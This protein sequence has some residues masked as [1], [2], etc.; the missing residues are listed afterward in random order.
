MRNAARSTLSFVPSTIAPMIASKAPIA[1]NGCRGAAE[2]AAI[3]RG[4][5]PRGYTSPITP[6][7]T[8]VVVDVS[9]AWPLKLVLGRLPESCELSI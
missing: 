9:L 2:L 7:T 1:T 8:A 5:D 6:V 3:E 4:P